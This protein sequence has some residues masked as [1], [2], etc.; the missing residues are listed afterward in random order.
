MGNGQPIAT[1]AQPSAACAASRA[2]T[3]SLAPTPVSL[4]ASPKPAAPIQTLLAARHKPLIMA[5]N[6]R[7]AAHIRALEGES[8]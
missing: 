6:N 1:L 4:R 5:G 8:R 7:A 3:V 2:C